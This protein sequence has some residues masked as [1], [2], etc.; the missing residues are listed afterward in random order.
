[1]RYLLVLL[2]VCLIS[3]GPYSFSSGS[4]GGI[5]S[6]AVPQFENTSLQYGLQE[7]LTREVI[8]RLIQDNTLR[9]LAVADADAVLRGEVIRYDR[10]PYTYD[11]S[12][13]V[14]EYRVNIFVNY[15]VERK[16]GKSLLERTNV[17]GFGVYSAATETE[18]DGKL[19]AIDKLARDIVDELTKTW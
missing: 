7:D 8:N 3:C 13:N 9:V 1:M 19:E 4:L 10:V 2:S 15:I 6:I 12:E 11:K 18:D 14:S 5:K 16:G 17:Q